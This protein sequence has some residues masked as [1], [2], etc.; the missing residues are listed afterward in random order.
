MKTHPDPSPL[1]WHLDDD[2]DINDRDGYYVSSPQRGDSDL[3]I[4][5]VNSRADLLAVLAAAK[6]VVELPLWDGENCLAYA[7]LNAAISKA[8]G[9]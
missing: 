4:L 3:I 7:D 2:G 8:E 6:A 1:P 9:A 5:A